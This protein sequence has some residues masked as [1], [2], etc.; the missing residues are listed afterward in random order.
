MRPGLVRA[1]LAAG[2]AAAIAAACVDR[3]PAQDRRIIDAA[4]AAKLTVDDLGRDYQQDPKAADR[5]YWGKALEV[6]G[7]VSRARDDAAGGAL[8]FA[9]KSGVPIVEA[10]LLEDQAKALLA[11]PAGSRVI[12][13]CYCAGKPAA[14]VVLTSCIAAAR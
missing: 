3:L 13:R 12:L 8:I 10:G 9:D 1:L 4:P 2:S 14:A 7:V 6:S 5:R 11:S